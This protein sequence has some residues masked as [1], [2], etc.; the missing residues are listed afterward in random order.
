M[1]ETPSHSAHDGH[2]P[3]AAKGADP[4]RVEG[5]ENFKIP[6]VGA[7]YLALGIGV[8]MLSSVVLSLPR[9][10]MTEARDGAA[11]SLADDGTKASVLAQTAISDPR[12][13]T[14]GQYVR[15]MQYIDSDSRQKRALRRRSPAKH[16]SKDAHRA[17]HQQVELREDA[18]AEVESTAQGSVHWHL[19]QDL[20]R[21]RADEP[22]R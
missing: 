8:A 20:Q 14:S 6:P 3:S 2:S 7:T 17:W 1:Q 5:T 12:K 21:L 13:L 18:V 16:D 11:E 9:L 15:A 19:Q 10:L 22:E 4:P